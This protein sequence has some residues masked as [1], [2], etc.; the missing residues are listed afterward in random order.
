MM[1]LSLRLRVSVAF[2]LLAVC[3]AF[4][5]VLVVGRSSVHAA[6]PR[7]K[8]FPESG[9]P[10]IAMFVNGAHFGINETVNIKFA[11]TALGTA[12]TDTNG[13]FIAPV[14]VPAT[15][16]PGTYTVKAQGQTSGLVDR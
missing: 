2:T 6:T 15:E 1:R 16:L 5:T 4:F 12:T 8:L 7:I 10:G 9:H 14:T 13:T 11:S 3:A